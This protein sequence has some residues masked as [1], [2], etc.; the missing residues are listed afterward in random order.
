MS[1]DNDVNEHILNT[2][3]PSNPADLKKIKSNLYTITDQMVLIAGHRDVIKETLNALHEEYKIPKK[4]LRK[5]AKTLFDAN[6]Y[7][8]SSENTQFEIMYEKILDK[9]EIDAD[10]DVD[11]VEVE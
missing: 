11:G 2:F 9:T 1:D 4:V 3:L 10:G 7:E 6:Y 8:V 5:L